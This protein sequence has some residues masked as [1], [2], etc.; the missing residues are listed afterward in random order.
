M[1]HSIAHV[2]Y[3]VKGIQVVSVGDNWCMAHV[4]EESKHP[5]ISFAYPLHHPQDLLA[6]C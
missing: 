6:D 4:R 5:S 3:L 2:N 1:I